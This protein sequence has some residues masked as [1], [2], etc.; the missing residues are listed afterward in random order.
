M[1]MVEAANDLKEETAGKFKN[2]MVKKRVAQDNS[3][4]PG[5]SK[6]TTT[7]SV[8]EDGVLSNTVTL[9]QGKSGETTESITDKIQM[10]YIRSDVGPYKAIVAVKTNENI[11]NIVRPPM[12]VEVSRALINMGVSFTLL[13]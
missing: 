6:K 4:C 5:K 12:D 7:Q 13:E 2:K 9:K 3:K 11:G 8:C 1:A 10:K